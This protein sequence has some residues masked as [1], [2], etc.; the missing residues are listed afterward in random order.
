MSLVTRD[1]SETVVPLKLG[2]AGDD[3]VGGGGAEC[4][5]EGRTFLGILAMTGRGRS[6]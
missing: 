4:T 5:G 6:Q 3:S 1:I 2:G